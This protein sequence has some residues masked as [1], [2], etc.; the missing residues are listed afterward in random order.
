MEI[1][2]EPT[3]LN[4]RKIKK[5]KSRSFQAEL[6][7]RFSIAGFALAIIAAFAYSYMAS[8]MI[9]RFY[10]REGIQATEN[11]AQLSAL[12]LL[13]D[14]GEN[15]K[16]AAFATLN[17]PSIKHVAIISAENTILLDEGETNEKILSSLDKSKWLDSS[18]RLFPSSKATWQ[19]A[20]PVYTVFND[21]S[22][23]DLTLDDEIEE[24]YLG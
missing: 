11:F 18:A 5:R 10:E 9:S 21:D 19:I 15:A 7:A 17:F 3:S 8:T 23:P 4:Q 14:S 13:Y 16:E 24:T 20:A 12:A 1:L 6:F 2:E 22:D